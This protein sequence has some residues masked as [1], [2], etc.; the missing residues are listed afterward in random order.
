MHRISMEEFCGCCEPS[1]LGISSSTPNRPGLTAIAYRIGTFSGFRRALLENIAWKDKLVRLTTRRSDDPAITLLELWAAVADVLTFYQ[2]RIANEAF[3][4][5]AVHRDSVLR[6]VRLLDYQLRPGIAATTRL[7]FT[8]DDGAKV[9]IPVGLR[10][11]STPGQ[12]ELPQTF[13]TIEGILADSRLNRLPILP[14]PIVINPFEEGRQVTFLTTDSHGWQAAKEL[15][16]AEKVVIF[17]MADQSAGVEAGISPNV[18]TPAA[19]SWGSNR[20]DVFTRGTDNV[21]WHKWWNGT[22]HDWESLGG[23]LTGAPAVCSWGENRLDVFTRGTDNALWHK[24]WNGTWHDWESLGGVLISAPAAVSWGS[25]RIDVFVRGTDNALWHKWWNGTWHDWESLGGQLTGAPAVCSW[26]ENRLDVFTRG[27][28]NALWHKWWN[29]TWHDWESL[30]GVLIS[31]PAAESAEP[32]SDASATTY[33]YGQILGWDT[34]PRVAVEPLEWGAQIPVHQQVTHWAD[35]SLPDSQVQTLDAEDPNAPEEK[36]I[37]EVRVEGDRFL[38]VWT[39]PIAK[40]T[41]VSDPPTTENPETRKRPRAYVFL[42]KMRVF[43]HNAPDTVPSILVPVSL[44]GTIQ[45]TTGKLERADNEVT[46]SDL[47]VTGKN[48]PLD[49]VYND[50]KVGEQLLVYEKKNLA[51]PKLVTIG[52]ISEG[53]EV[54]GG[55]DLVAGSVIDHR[56]RGTVTTVTV[57]QDLEIV[58][59]RDVTVYLLKGSEIP[60]WNGEF[61]PVIDSGRLYLPAVKLDPEGEAVEIGRTIEGRELKSGVALR[62]TDIEIDRPVLL[63]D[64]THQ[65]VSAVITSRELESVAGQDFLMIGVAPDS[66]LALETRSAVLLGNVAPATH[67]EAVKD[68]I[69]GDGDASKPFQR[70]ALRK[71]P[72][73]YVPSSQTARGEST[74]EVMING[75]KWKE[76]ESLYGE[77]LDGPVFTARQSDDATTSLQFGDGIT[78]RRLPTGPANVLATYRQG[79]G[80]AGRLSAEQLNIL[81]DRPVGLKAAVN[82]AA[83]EGGADPETLDQA[84][85][86]A[87]GTVV[88]FDR[89]VSLRDFEFLAT[90]S[91]EVARAKVTSVW[92]GLEEAVHLTVAGQAGGTFSPEALSRLQAGLTAHRDPNHLLLLDNVCRIPIVVRAKVRT[93]GRHD[94]KEIENN[95]NQALRDFFAFDNL[96][97]AQ[98]V[99]L[100]DLYLVLQKI[101]GVEAVDI[102]ELHFKGHNDWTA[103]QHA[104][105]GVTGADVQ[106]RLPIF[107]ARPKRVSTGDPAINAC[108]GSN[109]LP[110]ILPAE[111]AFVQTKS[112]D[113]TITV[114]EALE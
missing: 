57:S 7:A 43:G 36:V 16:P 45:T 1:T 87:P 95:A 37:K 77:S 55:N 101:D 99:H 46:D 111:Q 22:W 91:G 15:R 2:E 88:T 78:G 51:H 32:K 92:R 82:P 76:V 86:V 79:V 110:Q 48:L 96:G 8:V 74:L 62:L 42:R 49:A 24:W 109:P 83:T 114:V 9:R 28:D 54:L 27:T 112:E 25:N 80:L 85:N 44:G 94:P 106:A 23:Q 98:P 4:R 52:E 39:T 21:L 61:E 19:V 18:S 60:L 26:G 31:A 105:R 93:D 58:D 41:W 47:A 17:N 65:P 50:L 73:T 29:G 90:A 5:T 72:L 11:M 84:R 3:L 107:P 12:D 53:D 30:G 100:S 6:L 13:E 81:L 33:T 67:G 97:F 20:I 14:R 89:A 70:F 113:L 69:V 108:F 40:D 71:K 59:R 34:P 68:E 103:A 102:D 75:E 66:A 64:H 63:E 56:H 104:T 10:V 35:S 38:L